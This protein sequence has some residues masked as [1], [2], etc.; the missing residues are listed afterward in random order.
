MRRGVLRRHSLRPRFRA[1]DKADSEGGEKGGSGCGGGCVGGT[2]RSPSG[3]HAAKTHAAK[4]RTRP[5]GRSSNAMN[6]G[7]TRRSPSGLRDAELKCNESFLAIPTPRMAA[8]QSKWR[9]G[10]RPP[11]CLHSHRA[12]VR[13]QV[14][15][16]LTRIR[17][18]HSGPTTASDPSHGSD[19]SHDY[20]P[21]NRR[22]RLA[23][24]TPPPKDGRWKIGSENQRARWRERIRW[25]EREIDR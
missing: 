6:H 7:G 2:R 25:R 15:F 3:L 22:C 11:A 19:P 16:F 13:A 21:E 24:S 17:P 18:S 12:N 9:N 20:K 8:V 14:R 5:S 23:A 10:G 4:R 1:D